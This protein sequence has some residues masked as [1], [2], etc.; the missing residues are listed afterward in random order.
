MLYCGFWWCGLTAFFSQVQH[1]LSFEKSRR[2]HD[3]QQIT[4]SHFGEEKRLHLESSRHCLRKF[5]QNGTRKQFIAFPNMLYD[6]TSKLTLNC[7]V[8]GNGTRLI[9]WHKISFNRRSK[10]PFIS[11]LIPGE[12]PVLHASFCILKCFLLIL[13]T[14]PQS[15]PFQQPTSQLF[16]YQEALI[17][18]K[19]Y[20]WF[21]NILFTTPWNMYS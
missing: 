12:S 8:P 20:S 14:V 1:V 18:T 5:V 10:R 21:Q 2:C 16:S 6:G 15:H 17:G 9:Q 13:W 11:E 7:L 4:V 3:N 19:M